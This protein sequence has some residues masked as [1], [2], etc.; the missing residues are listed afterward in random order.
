[1]VGHGLRRA[2]H[3]HHRDGRHP[4]GAGHRQKDDEYKRFL[5]FTPQWAADPS[6]AP[7][8]RPATGICS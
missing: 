3:E 7:R 8:C 1:M 4:D 2:W 6:A 5:P